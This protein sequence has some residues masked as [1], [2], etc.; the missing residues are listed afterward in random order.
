MSGR[1]PLVDEFF[2]EDLRVLAVE[3]SARFSDE[4]S[5]SWA[6]SYGEFEGNENPD[7]QL[8]IITLSARAARGRASVTVGGL[9]TPVNREDG[10]DPE[11]LANSSA[12]ENLYD[13]AG[14]TLRQAAA[15][16]GAK[17]TLPR[18]SPVPTLVRVPVAESPAA[19]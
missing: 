18:R 9:V 16:V 4:T 10:I 13:F 12:L 8:I 2:I 5:L 1:R 15:T 17:I 11:A 3:A 19:G 14:V 6:G 7:V